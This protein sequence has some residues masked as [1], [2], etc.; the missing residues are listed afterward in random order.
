MKRR[1][2]CHI[3]LLALLAFTTSC[4][5]QVLRITI[6]VPPILVPYYEWLEEYPGWHPAPQM[7]PAPSEP[8]LNG[9]K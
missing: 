9:Y 4:S 8:V 3:I 7:T 5:S 1:L 6:V 2:I